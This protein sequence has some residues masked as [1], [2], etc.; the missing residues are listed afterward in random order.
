MGCNM[1]TKKNL[2]LVKQYL[3]VAMNCHI[4]KNNAKYK[5]IWYLRIILNFSDISQIYHCMIVYM[6]D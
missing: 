5:K 1:L 6:I 2:K 3:G 4:L